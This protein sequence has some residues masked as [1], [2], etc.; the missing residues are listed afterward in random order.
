ML[1]H[2]FIIQFCDKLETPMEALEL[3]RRCPWDS[4]CRNWGEVT[5]TNGDTKIRLPYNVQIPIKDTYERPRLHSPSY[6]FPRV[7]MV[8]SEYHPTSLSSY[9]EAFLPRVHEPIAHTK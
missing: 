2:W 7:Y 3:H 4:M 5:L 8:H 9:A 1:Y 6:G